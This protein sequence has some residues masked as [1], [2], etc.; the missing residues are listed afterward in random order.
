MR[1]LATVLSGLAMAGSLAL[2]LTGAA[3]AAEETLTVPAGTAPATTAQAEADPFAQLQSA[4]FTGNAQDSAK[5]NLLLDV[6]PLGPDT[7]SDNAVDGDAG[8]RAR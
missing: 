2:G 5:I 6:D 3:W 8:A 7:P 4:D 1:R